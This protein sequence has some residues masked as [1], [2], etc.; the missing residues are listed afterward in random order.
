MEYTQIELVDS[1][2]IGLDIKRLAAVR[3]HCDNFLLLDTL[4]YGYLK[5][6]RDVTLIVHLRGRRGVGGG[7]SIALA[8][9][10]QAPPVSDLIR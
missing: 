1:R 3:F 4:C 10:W 5:N 9:Y 2:I 8:D 6:L 7:W